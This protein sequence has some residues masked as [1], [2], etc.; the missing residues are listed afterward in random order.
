MWKINTHVLIVHFGLVF[1][2]YIQLY[3]FH[4][5]TYLFV[6]E[7]EIYREKKRENSHVQIYWDKGICLPLYSSLKCIFLWMVNKDEKGEIGRERVSRPHYGSHLKCMQQPGLE[8]ATSGTPKLSLI[9]WQKPSSLSSQHS[10]RGCTS[11]S[12]WIRNRAKTQTM[13][14][15]C[16][17]GDPRCVFCLCWTF[18]GLCKLE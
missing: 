7:K 4:I 9:G 17:E 16:E 18:P 15:L 11:V 5:L 2:L 3:T 12:S 6:F 8:P 14:F 1:Y 10:F 13:D